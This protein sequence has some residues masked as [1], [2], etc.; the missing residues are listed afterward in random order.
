MFPTYNVRKERILSRKNQSIGKNEQTKGD[1]N[2]TMK[3]AK[4]IAPCSGA[5][6]YDEMAL[7]TRS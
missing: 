7:T 5:L 6:D 3:T 4:H 2:L 1:Q